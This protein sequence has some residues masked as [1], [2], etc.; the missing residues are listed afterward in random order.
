MIEIIILKYFLVNHIF[1]LSIFHIFHTRFLSNIWEVPRSPCP[2]VNC[3]A[4]PRFWPILLRW[5]VNKNKTKEIK[6]KNLVRKY[7]NDGQMKGVQ[8]QNFMN[9]LELVQNSMELN[10][11]RKD[12]ELVGEYQVIFKILWKADQCWNF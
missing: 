1:K 6:F 9:T 2:P 4:W 12:R 7:A 3:S 11:Y 5:Q 8:K 10:S